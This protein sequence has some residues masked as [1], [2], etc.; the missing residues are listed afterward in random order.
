M[1]QKETTVFSLCGN[2]NVL[3]RYKGVL[4]YVNPRVPMLRYIR[5]IQLNVSKKKPKHNYY[6]FLAI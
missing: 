5:G 6:G 4:L 1:F 3:I 2:L